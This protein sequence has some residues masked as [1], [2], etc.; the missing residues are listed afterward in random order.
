M[1]N[2]HRP[3]FLALVAALTA[4][5]T[6]EAAEWVAEPAVNLREEYN[7]NYDL[8]S[9]DQD[10]VWETALEP[11]I[12]LSRR[13]DLWD[14]SAT[15]RLVASQFCGQEGLDTVDNYFNV[16][17]KRPFERGSFDA[18]ASLIND[19]TFQNEELDFDTGDTVRQV[20][21]TRNSLSLGGEY[22]LNET[23]WLDASLDY[24]MVSYDASL[25]DRLRDQLNDYDTLTPGLSLVH[26]FNQQTQVFGT[27]DHS[28]TKYDD[29]TDTESKTDSLQLG[30]AYDITETWQARASVGRQRTTLSNVLIFDP[31]ARFGETESTGTVYDASIT[32]EFETGR[33]SLSASQS[34]EP[35]SSGV[36]EERTR[37]NL[38]GDYRFSTK[39]SARLAVS[40]NQSSTLAA[41][42]IRGARNQDEYRYRIAPSIRWRLDEELALNT[43]Y[44]FTRVER[45]RVIDDTADSNVVFVSL[46]YS[47]PRMSISR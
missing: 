13:S 40:Y 25:L 34:A 15:E 5:F 45:D 7:D 28:E 22:M 17:A 3:T 14:I 43:G 35:S 44:S 21:R 16:A 19:T 32:R 4:S 20:D 10:T 27:L 30:A 47:W 31:V 6:A 1:L 33:I 41:G 2:S 29:L 46:G 18:N 42:A 24:A 37:I 39:L 26:Q 11:S 12:R 9:V 38:N 23:N 36:I 8:S